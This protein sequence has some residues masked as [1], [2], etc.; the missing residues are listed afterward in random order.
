M[1]PV[2]SNV[3][4]ML[5]LQSCQDPQLEVVRQAQ[6]CSIL[7]RDH[8]W[9]IPVTQSCWADPFGARSGQHKSAH[10]HPFFLAFIHP[11]NPMFLSCLTIHSSNSH[12]NQL[13]GT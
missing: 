3:R 4:T 12:L 8:W 9:S 10:F 1:Q 2:D 6:K 13:H 11:L 5:I 7:H